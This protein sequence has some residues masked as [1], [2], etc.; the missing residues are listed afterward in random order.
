LN[1]PRRGDATKRILTVFKPVEYF[2][3]PDTKPL[4]LPLNCPK[5]GKQ[6]G[7]GKYMHL[8]NCKG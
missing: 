2:R 5:C 7:R 8:K 4:P 3:E 6:L 1:F